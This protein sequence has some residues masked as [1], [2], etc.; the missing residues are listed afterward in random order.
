MTE[1]GQIILGLGGIAGATAA[2]IKVVDTIAARRKHECSSGDRFGKLESRVERHD[3]LLCQL[4]RDI[5]KERAATQQDR[6]DFHKTLQELSN[7]VNFIKGRIETN[8]N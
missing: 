6:R 8:G 7:A 3:E 2:I 1:I 5:D 4:G